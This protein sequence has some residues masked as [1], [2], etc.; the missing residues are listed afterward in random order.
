MK[1]SVF[2]LIIKCF[3]AVC[4]LVAA[5]FLSI[6]IGEAE[7]LFETPYPY[8][9]IFDTAYEEINDFDYQAINHIFS[10][11]NAEV[12]I[13]DC[14]WENGECQYT[15][16]GSQKVLNKFSDFTGIKEGKYITFLGGNSNVSF[17]NWDDM[18]DI[19]S[20]TTTRLLFV[21]DKDVRKTVPAS[22]VKSFGI[23][24][25]KGKLLDIK[26]NFT[27]IMATTFAVL[28]AFIIVFDIYQL[29]YELKESTVELLLG[30]GT[31]GVFFK[32]VLPYNATMITAFIGLNYIANAVWRIMVP[33]K[34]LVISYTIILIIDIIMCVVVPRLNWKKSLSNNETSWLLLTYSK[35]LH[36]VIMIVLIALLAANM[37]IYHE[38][39]NAR[40]HIE[41]YKYFKDYGSLKPSDEKE[42]YWYSLDLGT[43]I[44]NADIAYIDIL[45][46]GKDVALIHNVIDKNVIE[47]NSKTLEYVKS[48]N[49]SIESMNFEPENIYLLYPNINEY[50]RLFNGERYVPFKKGELVEI[51]YSGR[52]VLPITSGPMF[53]DYFADED[54]SKTPI[55]IV[56]L[57]SAETLSKEIGMSIS[58]EIAGAWNGSFLVKMGNDENVSG[59]S[60]RMILLNNIYDQYFDC[61][62][63]YV[64]KFRSLIVLVSVIGVLA[65]II[66]ARLMKLEFM[67]KLDLYINRKL[68][69]E[70]FVKRY[71]RFVLGSALISILGIWFALRIYAYELD[72]KIAILTGMACF[73]TEVI[74]QFILAARL[75]RESLAKLVK[76]GT[77]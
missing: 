74:I 54:W 52:V 63:P 26:A 23:G 42:D 11:Y 27:H 57:Q 56:N 35:M 62:R 31:S 76:G 77:L 9:E 47:I 70:P 34:I 50:N 1:K 7:W 21:S 55:L 8:Y 51:Q 72:L 53:V 30:G 17:Y 49:N 3:F 73:T 61:I 16:I 36:V 43:G 39:K 33:W 38:Y 12:M 15:Y 24:D 28:T 45:A 59:K 44:N 14:H 48:Q 64:N 13:R 40:S 41:F 65:I 60:G 6:E 75:E 4:L 22:V 37:N 5:F 29:F 2:Q 46:G 68:V 32:K 71:G 19:S 25:F 20:W 58:E 10:E 66:V 18:P 69:G 67:M